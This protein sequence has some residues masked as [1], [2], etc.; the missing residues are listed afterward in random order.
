MEY[1]QLRNNEALPQIKTPRPFKCVVIIDSSV[2]QEWQAEVSKWLVNSGCLFM[3]AWGHNCSSWD[4]SVD[5]ANLEQFEYQEIPPESF[6]VTTWHD[7]ESLSEVFEFCKKIA[8]HNVKNLEDTLMLHISNDN[9]SDA[10]KQAYEN[11]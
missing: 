4:D 2:S 9:M 3:M 10:I 6:V 11:A 7:S 5:Y 8:A 1:L